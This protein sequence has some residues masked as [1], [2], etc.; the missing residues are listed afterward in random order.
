MFI[1]RK[2]FIAIPLLIICLNAELSKAQTNDT[3]YH[4]IGLG[5]SYFPDPDLAGDKGEFNL[6]YAYTNRLLFFKL[7]TGIA[8]FTNFG[9]LIRVYPTIGISTKTRKK[10][11]WHLGVGGG[12]VLSTEKYMPNNVPIDFISRS[13]IGNTGF[14]INPTRSK[15]ILLGIDVSIGRYGIYYNYN[16][17]NTSGPITNSMYYPEQGLLIYSNF[18]VYYSIKR[19]NATLFKY[20]D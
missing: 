8:P 19:S 17:S 6:N 11:S 13:F 20:I 15:K 10:I 5:G 14:L 12:I 18:S 4:F 2:Y 16:S 7:E 3:A 9:N 1:K